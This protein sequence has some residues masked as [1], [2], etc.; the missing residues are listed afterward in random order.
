MTPNARM[1]VSQALALP[2]IRT[3]HL[4]TTIKYDHNRLLGKRN[5]AN[6][7]TAKYCLVKICFTIQGLE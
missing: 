5:S 2:Y 7:V 3:R 6:T 4:G 1:R